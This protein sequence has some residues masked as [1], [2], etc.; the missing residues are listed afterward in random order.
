MIIDEQIV[1]TGSYNWT[2]AAENR[3]AENLIIIHQ[4]DVARQY[5]EN[6]QKRKALSV[7]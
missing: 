3:N 2:N 6:F 7:P 1:V 5:N 4:P